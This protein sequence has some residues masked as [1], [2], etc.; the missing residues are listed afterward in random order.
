[1]SV[2]DQQNLLSFVGKTLPACQDNEDNPAPKPPYQP[3][4]SPFFFLFI[5]LAEMRL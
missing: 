1:M 4:Y 2:Q 3:P 5:L